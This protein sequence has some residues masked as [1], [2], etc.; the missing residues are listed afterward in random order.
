MP[1]KLAALRV[2]KC[3]RKL[4]SDREGKFLK[5]I[6]IYMKVSVKMCNVSF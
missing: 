2:F 6:L 3:L 1:Y 4:V 5:E